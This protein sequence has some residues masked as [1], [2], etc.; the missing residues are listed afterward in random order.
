MKYYIYGKQMI[1]KGNNKV[2]KFGIKVYII[3]PTRL[4]RVDQFQK[5]N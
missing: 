1:I 4:V 5:S 3:Y 2:L